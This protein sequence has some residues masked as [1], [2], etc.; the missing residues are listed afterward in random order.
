MK[1]AKIDNLKLWKQFKKEKDENKKIELRKQLIIIYYP[2]VKKIAYSLAKK[3][4]WRVTPEENCSSGI[5]GLISAINNFD[6]RIGCSFPNFANLR[7][8]G[9]M[10]DDLRRL[11]QTSRSTRKNFAF[12]EKIRHQLESEQGK[13]VTEEEIIKKAGLNLRDFRRNLK[14][15]HPISFSSIEGSNICDPSKQEDFQQDSNNNLID[16]K[17]TAP[18]SKIVRTEFLSK[19]LSRNFSIIEQKIIYMYYYENLTMDN[20][21]VLLNMS[22]SRISQIHR[23]VLIKL[24]DKIK[25]NPTYFDKVINKYISNCKD[26]GPLF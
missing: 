18:D 1:K 4:Q 2:L 12:L 22:E 19:I 9:S 26:T 20:I 5:E 10:I 24:K 15:Y 17:T 13:K 11:D 6:T 25:R 16:T 23:D 21:S 3:I 8:R 14:K 7:V